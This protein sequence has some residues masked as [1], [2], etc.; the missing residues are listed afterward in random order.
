MQIEGR[1]KQTCTP[2]S[3]YA[4][5]G[6]GNPHLFDTWFLNRRNVYVPMTKN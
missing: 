2:S 4:V 1:T 5:M 3:V 6:L